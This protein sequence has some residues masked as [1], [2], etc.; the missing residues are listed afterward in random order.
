MKIK[1]KNKQYGKTYELMK[2]YIPKKIIKEK[3]KELN[4]Q[5]DYL[6]EKDEGY[7]QIKENFNKI[8]VLKEIL[9]KGE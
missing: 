9:E 2:N 8:D 7:S 3:I 4:E 5:I 6:I 1:I